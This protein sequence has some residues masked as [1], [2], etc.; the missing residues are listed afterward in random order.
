MPIRHRLWRGEHDRGPAA[1]GPD[2][3]GRRAG[4]CQRRH[5]GLPCRCQPCPRPGRAGPRC[6]GR[7]PATRRGRRRLARATGHV[8][9]A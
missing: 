1:G 9:P 7:R 4:Q 5:R 2:E 6:L 3:N 8:Q